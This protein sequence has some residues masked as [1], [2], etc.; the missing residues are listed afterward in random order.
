MN[1]AVVIAHGMVAKATMHSLGIDKFYSRS[2]RNIEYNDIPNYKYIFFCLPTPTLLGK[3][4][5]DSI[6]EYIKLITTAQKDK[7]D[8]SIVIIRSTILPGTCKKIFKESNIHVVHVPEF[9][10]ES[11]WEKDSEW[12]DIIVIGSEDQNLRE[13]VAGIF[14]ARFKGAEYFLTDTQT[15]EMIKYAI[16]C[17]YALKVIYANQLFDFCEKENIP[18][19]TIK[20][21]MYSRKWIGKNHL[22]IWHNGGRG[23][24]GKC[25]KKDLDAFANFSHLPL[26]EY[27]E[28]LNKGYILSSNKK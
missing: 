12:P 9:L 5:I 13:E 6:R 22:D 23:A 27:A 19:E 20:K 21:A 11:T 8:K 1:N 3:Q 28:K 14:R 4:N 16:N 10:T 25:L 7:A 17:Y 2:E 15:S 26:L 18:Y 24:A